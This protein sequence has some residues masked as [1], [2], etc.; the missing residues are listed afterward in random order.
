MIELD[1]YQNFKK[2]F[3][4]KHVENTHKKVLEFKQQLDK[5]LKEIKDLGDALG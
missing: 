3:L 2:D 1:T 4:T 5:N